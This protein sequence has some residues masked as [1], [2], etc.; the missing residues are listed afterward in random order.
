M[1]YKTNR[2]YSELGITQIYLELIKELK[3]GNGNK[4][5]MSMLTTLMSVHENKYT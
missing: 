1:Q 2:D 3:F 4:R 5:Y